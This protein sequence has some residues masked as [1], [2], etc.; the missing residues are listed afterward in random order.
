MGVLLRLC[1]MVYVACCMLYVVRVVRCALRVACCPVYGTCCTPAFACAADKKYLAF[2]YQQTGWPA[3][4]VNLLGAHIQVRNV[5]IRLP[6][7]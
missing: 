1:C 6:S 4:L 2:L 5:G 7:A 3:E